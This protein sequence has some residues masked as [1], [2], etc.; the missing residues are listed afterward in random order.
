MSKKHS[1]GAQKRL[2]K[3]LTHNLLIQSR[4]G[5]SKHSAKQASREAWLKEHGSLKGWNPAKA[6]GIYS[7]GTMATYIGAVSGLARYA[8]EHGAGGRPI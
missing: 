1:N 6:D 8:A 2:E 4:M 7:R 3:A 5:Q